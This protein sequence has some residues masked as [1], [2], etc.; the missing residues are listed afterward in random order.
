VGCHA[1]LGVPGEINDPSFAAH[2]VRYVEGTLHFHP[3]YWEIGNE[4]ALWHHWN[5]PWSEWTSG[6]D[7]AATPSEFASMVHNYAKAIHGVDP[8]A[9]IIGLPGTGKGA[10]GETTWIYDVM[11]DSGSAIAAL[12]IHVY[13]AGHLGAVD[14]TLSDFDKTL[15]DAS[16]L[17][18]RM[19]GDWAAVRKAC[20]S[21]HVEFFATEMNA[22]STGYLANAGNYGTFME[23]F[24]EVPYVAALMAQGLKTGMHDLQLFELQSA[25][26]G[27]MYNQYGNPRPV[28]QLYKGILQ[29][30]L[31]DAVKTSVSGSVGEFFAVALKGSTHVQILLV[32]ANPY[33]SV[34]LGLSSSGLPTGSGT[35]WKYDSGMSKP[36]SGSWYGSSG[37]TLSAESVTL[38]QVN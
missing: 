24:P 19:P 20:S 14:G 10:Y 37:V 36:S 8:N 32:N 4:P 28:A 1:V 12:A 22:A 18:A 34:H 33:T 16:S 29:H 38:I 17:T 23:T 30:L 26:Q 21:C 6:Q 2:E 7:I 15:S 27:G 13:P 5:K 9:K 31:P 3:A 11:H 25:Y 35:I